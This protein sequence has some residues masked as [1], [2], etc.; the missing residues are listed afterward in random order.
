MTE[1]RLEPIGSASR[2]THARLSIEEQDIASEPTTSKA[3]SFSA[4]HGLQHLPDDPSD[5]P[6][7]PSS[8]PHSSPHIDRFAPADPLDPNYIRH[9]PPTDGGR[10]AWLFLAA[11]TTVEMLI[12]GLPYSI[13]VLH[14]YW[15]S[16]LFGPGSESLVTLAATLQAGL[17]Y[18]L[19]AVAG[20]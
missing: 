9:L 17:M 8:S 2:A 19:A 13:G 7:S 3:A 18:M 10:D 6:P 14:A 20:P 5:E 4:L 12:W 11:S 16:K 1:F 15:T